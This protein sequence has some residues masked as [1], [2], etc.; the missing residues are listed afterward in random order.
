MY[1][2]IKKSIW[3][4]YHVR[5]HWHYQPDYPDCNPW[6]P[7]ILCSPFHLEKLHWHIKVHFGFGPF[8]LGVLTVR[9]LGSVTSLSRKVLLLNRTRQH[10]IARTQHACCLGSLSHPCNSPLYLPPRQWQRIRGIWWV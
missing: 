3:R 9:L 7:C 5:H 1:T 4:N 8:P 2:L 10:L 6:N